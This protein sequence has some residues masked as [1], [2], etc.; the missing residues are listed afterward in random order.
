M[1][2][3]SRREHPLFD[4]ATAD[5]RRSRAP[6][7][8][9][10]SEVELSLDGFVVMPVKRASFCPEASSPGC[11]RKTVTPRSRHHRLRAWGRGSDYNGTTVSIEFNASSVEAEGTY[12][13]VVRGRNVVVDQDG[14]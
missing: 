3:G 1:P 4:V 9:S 14:D 8:E 6:S 2:L 10:G 13:E 5:E 11:R 12:Q 7:L